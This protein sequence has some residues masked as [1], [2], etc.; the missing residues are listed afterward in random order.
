MLYFSFYGIN[1]KNEENFLVKNTSVNDLNIC[2]K[3]N[4][5][6]RFYI[7]KNN[8]INYNSG[9]I[10]FYGFNVNYNMTQN[11]NND[12]NMHKHIFDATGKI[13]D[14]DN[15]KVFNI[16]NDKIDSKSE[17]QDSKK[18]SCIDN[19]TK[20]FKKILYLNIDLQ[21]ELQD[22]LEDKLQDELQDY[23]IIRFVDCKEIFKNPKYFT[24][25]EHIEIVILEKISVDIINLPSTIKELWL[26]NTVDQTNL[27]Y[28]LQKLRLYNYTNQKY[29]MKIP[30]G[31]IVEDGCKK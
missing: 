22:E 6:V 19:W 25:P 16:I 31:C 20:I 1:Y 9:F 10:T 18:N 7:L 8:Y 29:N 23:Q 15:K 27:P 21:D 24:I 3:P 12:F 28:N 2:I 11:I 14:I 17:L 30:F 13:L 5:N 4:V 26:I